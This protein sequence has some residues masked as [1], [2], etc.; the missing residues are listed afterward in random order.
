VWLRVS[1]RSILLAVVVMVAGCTGGTSSQP[2]GTPTVSVSPTLTPEELRRQPE[3]SIPF[4]EQNWA[5]G[6]RHYLFVAVIPHPNDVCDNYGFRGKMTMLVAYQTDCSSFSG[7]R[8]NDLFFYVAVRNVTDA[9][10]RFDLRSFTLDAQDG[11]S[12][13]AAAVHQRPPSDFL[14]GTA[15]IPPRSNVFGY[16]AFNADAR[17]VVPASLNYDDGRQTLMVVFDGEPARAAMR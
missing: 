16:V 2:S 1:G 12:F 8:R 6:V 15:R 17:S 5:R 10:S 3:V 11:R 13:E 4:S 9:P 7:G 14:P